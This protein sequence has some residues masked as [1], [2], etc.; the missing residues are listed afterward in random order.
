MNYDIFHTIKIIYVKNIQQLPKSLGHVT[1]FNNPLKKIS[2][3]QCIQSATFA[4]L[5]KK[6]KTS[7]RTGNEEEKGNHEVGSWHE[8]IYLGK[9]EK[10]RKE[11][12]VVNYA[13][14]R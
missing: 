4:A 8:V 2:Q 14:L 1:I 5:K 6:N 9:K 3:F 11:H 10:E 7:S 12:S 13:Y